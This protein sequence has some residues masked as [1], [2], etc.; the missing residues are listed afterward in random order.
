M[1]LA[2]QKWGLFKGLWR[3]MYRLLRCHPCGGFGV[4]FPEKIEEK[5]ACP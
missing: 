5:K 2:L 1:I 4:D 3:G